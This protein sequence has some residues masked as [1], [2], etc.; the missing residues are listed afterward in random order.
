MLVDLLKK[1]EGVELSGFPSSRV[2]FILLDSDFMKVNEEV[3]KFYE[4]IY[5]LVSETT[6]IS[7]TRVFS[8]FPKLHDQMIDIMSKFVS[9]VNNI[10]I[11][12]YNIAKKL[13]DDIV[14]MNSNY[15]YFDE[16]EFNYDNLISKT[17]LSSNDTNDQYYEV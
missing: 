6:T 4:T 14:E 2:I 17:V 13:S 12:Q 8:R 7:L 1:S 10:L 15:L 11:Q 16:T 9:T 5:D 3:D